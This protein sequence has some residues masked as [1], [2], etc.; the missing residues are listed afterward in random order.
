MSKNAII[1]LLAVVAGVLLACLLLRDIGSKPPQPPQP[2]SESTINSPAHP[3][4]PAPS[5]PQPTPEPPAPPTP[6]APQPIPEPPPIR[7]ITRRPLEPEATKRLHEGPVIVSSLFEASGKAEYEKGTVAHRMYSGSYV[8]TTTVI[9][10]SEIIEKKE[11]GT[12]GEIFV[13]ER[14]KFLQ[15]RDSI[16]LSDLDAAIKLDLL[17]IDKVQIWVDNTCNLVAVTCISVLKSSPPLTPI[18]LKIAAGAAATRA[19][20]GTAVATLH[21]IDG[22]S[23][24][25]MLGYHGIKPPANIEKFLND[26]AAKLVSNQ[27]GNI[28]LALQEIEGKSFI[29]TYKQDASGKPLN[30]DFDHE[31]GKPISDAEWEILRSANAFIDSTV[32]PDTECSVGD[33]WIIWTDEIMDMFNIAGSGRT[34]GR[35]KVKRVDD[36]P[37][38]TWTLEL[39]PTPIEF[40]SNDKTTIG[41]MQMKGGNG[42]VDAKNVSV[43]TLQATAW[44]NLRHLDKKRHW[45]LFESVKRF[46]GNSNLRFSITVKP[47]KNGIEGN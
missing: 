16:S 44:G 40:V 47:A 35:I 21:K 1:T 46:D 9:A 34:E 8:Y 32:V 24:R 37:D 7:K 22:S 27:L 14:R 42:L 18:A 6:P 41:K 28:H 36:Q 12:E 31:D 26:K 25:G 15:A 20:V 29:I 23:V 17:P 3:E 5:A 11:E 30:I 10:Q 2:P 19:I 38:G 43:K 45:L 4:P 33:D 13:K 39:V